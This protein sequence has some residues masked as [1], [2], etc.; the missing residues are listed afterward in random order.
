MRV[1]VLG[2]ESEMVVVHDAVRPVVNLEDLSHLVNWAAACGV[3]TSYHL[4]H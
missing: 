4:R 1:K 3:S 2:K